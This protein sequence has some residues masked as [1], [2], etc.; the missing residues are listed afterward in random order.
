MAV[1]QYAQDYDERLPL[2]T[3]RSTNFALPTA[4]PNFLGGLVPY[5]KSYRVFGCPSAVS[6]GTANEHSDTNYIGNAVVMQRSMAEIQTPADLV[7]LQELQTRRSTAYL[8]PHQDTTGAARYRYWFFLVNGVV[9]YCN[10][11]NEGG[12]VVFCDGH[13]QWRTWR[14]MRSRFFGLTSDTDTNVPV[15][16][17]YTAVF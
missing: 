12:N 10:I 13:A 5:V 15:D 8:R 6:D 4:P 9:S 14:G 2:R 16:T 7:Y 3:E 11:H 1:F 17:W